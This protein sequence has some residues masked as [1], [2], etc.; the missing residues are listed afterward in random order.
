KAVE[1]IGSIAAGVIRGLQTGER[2]LLLLAV[3]A[4]R[5][6]VIR[7][8]SGSRLGFRTRVDRYD[9]FGSTGYA[10]GIG[11]NQAA[12]V[13]GAGLQIE[14]AAGEHVGHNVLQRVFIDAL[15]I[16]A[17]HGQAFLPGGFAFL[18]I[19]DRGGSIVVVI[20]ID[21]PFETERN[22]RGTFDDE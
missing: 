4:G 13:V 11:E 9:V 14:D 5:I 17:E 21:V 8:A 22:E 20:A 3:E 16:H 12:L 19:E 6:H 15:V 10:I 2:R 1:V 18:A 7:L